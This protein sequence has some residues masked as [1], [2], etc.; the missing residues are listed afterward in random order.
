MTDLDETLLCKESY[1][2]DYVLVKLGFFQLQYM[3]VKTGIPQGLNKEK[4]RA[5]KQ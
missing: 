1:C 5:F 3:A 4:N 2:I